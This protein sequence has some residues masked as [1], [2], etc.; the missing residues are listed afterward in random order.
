MTPEK[1]PQDGL[2]LV[3]AVIGIIASIVLLSV[4]ISAF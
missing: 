3:I 1:Q 2:D 4:S